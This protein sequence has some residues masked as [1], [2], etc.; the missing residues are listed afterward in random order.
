[1]IFGGG[2]PAATA[3]GFSK[4]RYR[5]E[6]LGGGIT[7]TLKNKVAFSLINDINSIG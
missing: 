7:Q 4:T 6:N 5:Q 2:S 3:L 1:V